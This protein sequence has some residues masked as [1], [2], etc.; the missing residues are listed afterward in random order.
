MK[1]LLFRHGKLCEQFLGCNNGGG[2]GFLSK[3]RH[4][5]SSPHIPSTNKRLFRH[6]IR[7]FRNETISSREAI[8]R[9]IAVEK[10]DI[11]IEKRDI[12]IEKR[13]IA[14]L[15]LLRQSLFSFLYSTEYSQITSP[16]AEQIFAV[17]TAREF[18]SQSRI[19]VQPCSAGLKLNQKSR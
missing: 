15:T 19:F 10:R 1:W 8:S 2:G 12:D 13:D 11:A 17:T 3:E 18:W 9:D 14:P 5:S 4:I 16:Q 6:E 7:L